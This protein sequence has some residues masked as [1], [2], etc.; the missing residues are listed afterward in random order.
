VVVIDANGPMFCAG[1]DIREFAQT[2]DVAALIGDEL[3]HLNATLLALAAL[4]VPVIAAVQG[5]VAGGGI[6]LALTADIVIASA[7]LKFR[8]G[9]A[10]IGLSPDAGTSYHLA[11]LIGPMRAKEFLLTNRFID[12]A[13]AL[14]LGLV[15]K[16]VPDAE[17]AT[18]TAAL[19]ERIASLP[20]GSHA[21]VKALVDA[22][23]TSTHAAALER[24]REWMIR[25]AATADCREGIAAFVEKR[26][27]AFA[28]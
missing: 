28:R 25:N 21:A 17:L 8:A 22:S 20:A 12:A 15:V 1:G 9:Y 18:E 11:R 23:G 13:E 10:A 24:E 26:R 16:V 6:G 7:S 4:P 2:S 5:A 27:P 19:A 3:V 14:A